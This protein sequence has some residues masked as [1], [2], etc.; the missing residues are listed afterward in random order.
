MALPAGI[1]DVGGD[2][3]F[4]AHQQPRGAQQ[5][6]ARHFPGFRVAHLE[7][8]R[9]FT[10]RML[11]RKRL[12]RTRRHLR[13]AVRY[14]ACGHRRGRGRHRAQHADGR[15][16]VVRDEEARV[17]VAT[18]GGSRRQAH[19]RNDLLR[20][21]AEFHDRAGL[22]ADR[23]DA[24][25]EHRVRIEL[26]PG[27]ITLDAEVGGEHHDHGHAVVD[28]GD[29]HAIEA[30]DQVAG[31]EQGPAHRAGGIEKSDVDRRG[32]AR[33]AI[34]ARVAGV[35][36][37]ACRGLHLD[38]AERPGIAGQHA[39]RRGRAVRR[40]HAALD[41][42][43]HHRGEHVA[44]V[45]RGVDQRLARGH[46]RE[47]ELQVRAR[48]A[49]RNDADLAGQRIG[50][51][52]AVDLARVGGTHRGQ[53]HAVARRDVGGQVAGPEKRAMRRAAAHEVAG[54]RA[55]HTSVI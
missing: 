50:A 27:F 13:D 14:R 54:Y 22:Q 24:F 4:A 55:L 47:Q 16:A 8:H 32:G 1:P 52:D 7:H 36:H 30:I 44:A 39:Q 23:L 6:S 49:G 43:R 3:D 42:E 41:R 20:H 40:H 37:A 12:A 19:F 48:L 17:E 9:E 34:D 15:M 25:L 29:F 11:H 21:V 46:L 2:H 38:V 26:V 5:R 51:A 35:F 18:L 10:G 45:R 53:Q 31:G 28:A 33:H